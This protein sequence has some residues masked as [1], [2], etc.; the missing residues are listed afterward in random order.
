MRAIINSFRRWFADDGRGDRDF[1]DR[2]KQLHQAQ[3]LLAEAAATVAK[4]AG[5]LADVINIRH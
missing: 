3:K 4:A 2:E 5:I 1:S